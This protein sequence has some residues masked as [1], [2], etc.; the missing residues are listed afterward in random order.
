MGGQKFEKLGLAQPWPDRSDLSRSKITKRSG[1]D[2]NFKVPSLRNV[3]ETAPYFHNGSVPDLET[4]VRLM[5]KHQLG[6]QLTDS[7]ISSIVSFLKSL[8][9]KIPEDYIKE[10]A[11]P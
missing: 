10:P 8:T 6:K 5:G 7:D 9:G 3:A 1:N 11:L 2:M 4:A